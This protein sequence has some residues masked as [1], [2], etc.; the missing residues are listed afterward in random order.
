MVL[1]LEPDGAPSPYNLVLTLQQ[2]GKEAES[3]GVFE[4][5]F[6]VSPN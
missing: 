6:G 4:V 1:K 3:R 2:R 5:A